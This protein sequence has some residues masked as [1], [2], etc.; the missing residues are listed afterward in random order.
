MAS[1]EGGAKPSA[2]AGFDSTQFASDSTRIDLNRLDSDSP[3]HAYRRW[4]GGDRMSLGPRRAGGGRRSGW[5][6]LA[7]KK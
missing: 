3:A 2:P 6:R 4:G 5:G 7:L 1:E